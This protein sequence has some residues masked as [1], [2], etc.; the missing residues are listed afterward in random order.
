M[1]FESIDGLFFC[2]W[3][4]GKKQ[5]L[6]NPFLLKKKVTNKRLKTR[7]EWDTN[8]LRRNTVETEIFD[9][10]SNG[11]LLNTWKEILYDRIQNALK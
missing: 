7:D 6:G 10:K 2:R 5:P 9:L 4:T 8:G 3:W 11:Y 1:D